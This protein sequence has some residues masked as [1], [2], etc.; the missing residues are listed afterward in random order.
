MKDNNLAAN[1]ARKLR[2]APVRRPEDLNER[3]AVL[4]EN[5]KRLKH[6]VGLVITGKDDV[7]N[8]VLTALIG[9]GHV[10]LE[11]I[12]GVGKTTL[13]KSIARSVAATYARIQFTPDLLPSDITGTTVYSPKREEF[14]WSPGPLFAN[15]VLADEINRTS[16]RTQSALLEAMEEHQ[17][18]VDR[19]T[20]HLPEPFF[21]IATQNSHE[22]HGTFPLP[23]GQMDR[24]LMSLTIGLP[25]RLNEQQMLRD[26]LQV[27]PLDGIEPVITASEIVEL[28]E[29][30]RQVTI[31]DA[32]LNY[33]LDI[34]D[35]GRRHPEVSL[36]PSPRASIAMVRAS[37]GLAFAA[38]RSYVIPDDVQAAALPVLSHRITP[39]GK[40]RTVE[41]AGEIVAAVVAAS[42]VPV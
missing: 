10:L 28:Q 22:L 2:P 41:L 37:Q 39:R 38:G 11:D 36:G 12:P 42:R 5:F 31:T 35:N 34:I 19:I 13:A 27:H 25:D 4:A 7:I 21:V 40:V 23:E 30:V 18:T 14:F 16:P 33:I 15:I 6:N 20:H 8:F 24:F 17:V 9:G 32:V 3:F 29:A 26:Q 1:L